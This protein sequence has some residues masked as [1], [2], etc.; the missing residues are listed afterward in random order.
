MTVVRSLFTTPSR[1]VAHTRYV[2][3]DYL[4]LRASLPVVLISFIAWTFARSVLRPA[5]PGQLVDPRFAQ[6]MHATYGSFAAVLLYFTVFLAVVAVM[7][8]DRSAGYYRF[9]FS[10]PVNVVSYYLHTFCVHGAVICVLLALFALAWGTV[11]PHESPERAS[12]AGVVAFAL[13]GGLG[14]AFGALTDADAA[15]TPLS[16][17]FATSAQATL[18]DYSNPPQWLVITA[19]VLPPAADFEKTRRLLND[20]HPLLPAPLWHVLGYGAAAWVLGLIFLR[21]RPLAR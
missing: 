17:I 8:V 15:L 1:L 21:W 14:F 20:A 19:K 6:G 9:F 16:F 3:Q 5:R 10:K 12:L 11:M 18:V 4:L 2:L 13:I 7:T